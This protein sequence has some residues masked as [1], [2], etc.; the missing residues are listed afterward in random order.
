MFLKYIWIL[1]IHEI[2]HDK[3]VLFCFRLDQI[4]CHLFASFSIIFTFS[5]RKHSKLQQVWCEET[6]YCCI[7]TTTKTK[8]IRK[9][10]IHCTTYYLIVCN[11]PHVVVHLKRFTKTF[12]CFICC[13]C[14]VSKTWRQCYKTFLEKIQ[15]YLNFRNCTKVSSDT[16][17]LYEIAKV[18]QT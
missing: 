17:K 13:S 8:S 2:E 5:E 18:Q 16:L 10:L 11:C 14:E 1:D 3:Q 15:I 9:S 6:A 12:Y 4:S 7:T